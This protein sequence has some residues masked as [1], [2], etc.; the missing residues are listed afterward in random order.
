[1]EK[2]VCN[3]DTVRNDQWEY[4]DK[5]NER[6]YDRRKVNFYGG[7]NAIRTASLFWELNLTELTPVFTTKDEDVIITDGEFKGTYLFSINRLFQKAGDITEYKFAKEVFGS[8]KI[9]KRV[10]SSATLKKVRTEM[11]E[12]LELALQSEAIEVMIDISQEEGSRGASSAKWLAERGWSRSNVKSSDKGSSKS[13][14]EEQEKTN[15]NVTNILER[16]KKG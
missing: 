9:W 10:F 11:I 16:L 2:K 5:A 1:M 14:K 8:V 3:F 6:D 15:S 13:K 4:V 12:E 7:S